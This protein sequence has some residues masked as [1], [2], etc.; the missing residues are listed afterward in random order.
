MCAYMYI[1]M[2]VYI[3]M[4]LYKY[5]N[6]YIYIYICVYVY[7]YICIHVLAECNEPLIVSFPPPVYDEC[8]CVNDICM[9]EL[10][11]CLCLVSV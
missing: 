8:M 11:L 9:Y 10:V 1:Y 3:Y 7:I 2:Y 5:V 6:I 4:Y